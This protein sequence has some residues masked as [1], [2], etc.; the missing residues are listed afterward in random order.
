MSTLVPALFG[1]AG[2]VSG[3]V[4]RLP[5]GAEVVIGRSRSCPVSFRRIGGYLRANPAI[6]DNDHDFNTVS[7]RHLRLTV[8]KGVA[9][10]EDLSTNGSFYNGEGI[11]QPLTVDLN[12]GPCSLRLGTRETMELALVEADDPRLAGKDP[13]ATLG[14]D[15]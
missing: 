8:Q 3:E 5:E 2:L 14:G 1:T 15:D 12:R 4:F 13:V 7:R 10:I 11:T 6:R 9:S